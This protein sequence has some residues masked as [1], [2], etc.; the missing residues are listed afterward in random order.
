[1]DEEQIS[2]VTGLSCSVNLCQ[3]G[4]T[5]V[6]GTRGY[7][8]TCAEGWTGRHCD[9]QLFC[10]DGPCLNG[11]VCFEGSG[12]FYCFCGK[13]WKGDH[14][15]VDID[16]CD[17]GICSEGYG[18]VNSPGSY[19]CT[20][21]E[22]Y[23]GQYCDDI[24]ECEEEP[25]PCG[26]NTECENTDGSY[27][28][29]CVEGF[30]ADLGG[31]NCTDIDECD[32]DFASSSLCSPHASCTNTPG[33][34]VCTCREGYYG[35]GT[36][37]QAWPNTTIDIGT[38]VPA[39]TLSPPDGGWSVGSSIVALSWSPGD[40][41]SLDL[42][43]QRPGVSGPCISSD[44]QV[45]TDKAKHSGNQSWNYMRGRGNGQPGAG[46]PF[47]P[48]LN[49][50]VGRSDGNYTGQADSFYASFWFKTAKEY[51]DSDK[52][53]DGSRIL[54]AAGDPEGTYPSSNYLEVRLEQK[55]RAKVSVRTR[56]SWPSYEECAQSKNCGEDFG[57]QAQDNYQVVAE[58]LEPTEW[59]KVEMTLRTKPEDYADEWRYVVDDTYRAEGGAYYKT[60][61][62]D[63]GRYLYVNRLNFAALHPPNADKKGFYF[64]D[65]YYKAFD[66]SN[67]NVIIDE[68][69]TSFEATGN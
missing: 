8:C 60:K 54:V 19:T 21:A 26:E 57:Y 18:C 69:R 51:T 61:E 31:Y 13:G 39:P 64:D 29:N 65:V 27:T 37:C 22:G 63:E 12:S 52:W 2:D 56:E 10:T 3:N 36:L 1:M 15:E 34:Y 35:N 46:T 48:E 20:C 6:G 41:P 59:H 66:S 62:Y 43:C 33:S 67:P 38:T 40:A 14:C 24:N 23:S 45:I 68:Y 50:K 47:S 55:Y 17:A 53:G 9:K 7:T 5:C 44:Y 16:E 42:G 28:C 25:H 49:V 58:D 4:A 30:K 32:P 11:G